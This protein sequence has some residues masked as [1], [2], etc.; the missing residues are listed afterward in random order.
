M[1]ISAAS[2]AAYS[3]DSS[4]WR[5]LSLGL[6]LL[7]SIWSGMTNAASA[8]SRKAHE[9]VAA[10]Q[11]VAVG[12]YPNMFH[13]LNQQNSTFYADLY[14]WMRWKGE[15]DPTATAEFVNNV[16]KWGF[17]A[18]RIY[19]KPLRLKDG[20]SLQQLHVQGQFFQPLSLHDYPLD[21]HEL[22]IVIEDSTFPV[23]AR[24][25]KE[26]A[27]QSHLDSGI[28]LPG[29]KITDWKISAGPHVYATDFG[30]ASNEKRSAYSTIRFTLAVERPLNFFIWKLLLPL[31]IV[32]LLGCSALFVHPSYSDARLAAPA[33]ALLS[34]VFLQQTYSS[35]LPEVG[36]LVLLDKIYALAY[37]VVLLL[38]V[39]TIVTSSTVRT[40]DA[41]KIARAVVVDRIVVAAI[42]LVFSV[43][44][45][46]LIVNRAA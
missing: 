45:L 42:L 28:V 17:T 31:A 13:S 39:S 6:L 29:W 10:P 7:L 40:D 32:L 34:L 25:Y 43:G 5:A 33:A 44:T 36:Y 27:G 3:T 1:N 35:T 37:A 8:K 20:Q 15:N 16:E 4:T 2:T 23:D 24:V 22:S 21:K 26:D 46:W 14:L 41:S 38:M 9:F 18:T 11:E 19:E 12:F 30:A